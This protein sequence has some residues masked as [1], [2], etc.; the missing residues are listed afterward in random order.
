MV[1]HTAR[2]FIRVYPAASRVDS[3][4]YDP[5]IPWA[6]G[7]QMV[8]LNYQTAGEKMLMNQAMF[9]TNGNTGYVLKPAFLRNREIKFNPFEPRTYPRPRPIEYKFEIISGIVTN[10]FAGST[11]EKMG[12][13]AKKQ[14][15]KISPAGDFRANM[16]LPIYSLSFRCL[17]DI[18][19]LNFCFPFNTGTL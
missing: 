6:T 18:K 4:N 19:I 17:R 16:P 7:C 11:G 12:L 2:Q 8:A 9:R 5:I 10:I 1:Q 15:C 14:L 3:T 13:Y